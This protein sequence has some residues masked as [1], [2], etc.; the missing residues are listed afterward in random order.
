MARQEIRSAALSCLWFRILPI[1]LHLII[2]PGID[3]A[4]CDIVLRIIIREVDI[5]LLS[6]FEIEY[7]LV[8]V[9]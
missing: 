4:L 9:S 8:P 3:A 5:R 1:D 2:D 6:R 7:I